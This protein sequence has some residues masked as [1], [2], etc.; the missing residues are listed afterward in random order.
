MLASQQGNVAKSLLTGRFVR[1]APA[2]GVWS[3]VALL[4][5]VAVAVPRKVRGLVATALL[6]LLAA[7]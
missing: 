1:R 2:G 6:V 7:A 4:G 5:V 3:G